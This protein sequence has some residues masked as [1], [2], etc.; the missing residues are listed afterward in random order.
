MKIFFLPMLALPSLFLGISAAPSATPETTSGLE[1]RQIADAYSIVDSLYTEI[2]QYTGAIN[3][4]VAGV[5][6]DTSAAQNATAAASFIADIEAITAA[7]TAAT[8]EIDVLVPANATKLVRR[9]TEAALAS[10]VENL[11]L[12]ISGALN[13]IIGTLGLT[14]LLGSLNPLVS[15]LSALLLS[16]ENVVDDLLELVRELVDGLL[17]GLSVGLAGLDL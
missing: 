12:E 14:S 5:D 9:Q 2:Q 1:K 8:A 17:T 16:L 7:V 3:E 15:S 10:L 11:L 4:T 6:S 13:G